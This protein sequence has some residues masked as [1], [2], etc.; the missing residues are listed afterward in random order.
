MSFTVGVWIFDSWQ[1]SP[2]SQDGLH[3][4]ISSTAPHCVPQEFL[5]PCEKKEKVFPNTHDIPC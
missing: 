2:S 1:V 3:K 4:P 5:N